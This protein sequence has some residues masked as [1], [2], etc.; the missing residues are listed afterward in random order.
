MKCPECHKNHKKSLGLRCG[1]GY[2][3]T[4]IPDRDGMG[5]GAFLALVRRASGNGTYVFTMNQLHAAQV[6][7][8]RK[9]QPVGFFGVF[10]G[11]GLGFVGAMPLMEGNMEG[12]AVLAVSAV[13]VLIGVL[14]LRGRHTVLDQAN[15]K[16]IVRKWE[17]AKGKVP[18]LLK[19]HTLKKPPPDLGEGDVHDYGV[20]FMLVVQRE[21]LVDW[22]VLNHF[23]ADNRAMVLTASGYPEYLHDTAVRMLKEIPDLPV[24]VLHDATPEGV[25]MGRAVTDGATTV[26][27]WLRDRNAVDLGLFP[28]DFKR[29]K[30]LR[31]LK[32]QT[33]DY[34][35]PVDYLPF[36]TLSSGVALAMTEGVP[37]G[38]LLARSGQG[39]DGWSG[40]DGGGYG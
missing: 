2:R 33:P 20:E 18:G 30:R 11:L 12:A 13:L 1:C 37:L 35:F 28:D 26:A 39:T 29:I 19:K 14:V 32:A 25:A 23:H 40:G 15:L 36:A 16:S 38:A 7:G 27:Y 6:F 17:G 24:F 5:D 31:P 34:Q 8:R 22:L 3:F 10:F 9:R 4:L 21:E